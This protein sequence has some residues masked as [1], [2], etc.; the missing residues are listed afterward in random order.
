[1]LAPFDWFLL[2]I[3]YGYI[4]FMDMANPDC[5]NIASLVG[6]MLCVCFQA[7]R[8]IL[9]KQLVYSSLEETISPTLSLP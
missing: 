1:M 7:D 3:N 4:K 2:F 6:I 8:L 9:D 5:K